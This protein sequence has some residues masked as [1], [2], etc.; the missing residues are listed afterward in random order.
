V[1]RSAWF[2][3]ALSVGLGVMLLIAEWAG[4][5]LTGGIISLAIMT[6]FAALLVLLSRRSET[7]EIMRTT[8]RD[9]RQAMIDLRATALAGLVVILAVIVG[10]VWEVAHGRDPSP[11]T[12]L[13][14][15]GGVAYLVGLVVARR[16]S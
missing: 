12:Q 11:F 5:D 10:F 3:P 15:L 14:A 2:T 7:V 4:G 8:Q 1:Y 6:G 9:E 16:R 13:G